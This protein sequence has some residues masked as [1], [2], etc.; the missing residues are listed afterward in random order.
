MVEYAGLNRRH[1]IGVFAYHLG[2]L[3]LAYLR[4]LSCQFKHSNNHTST[5]GP[6]RGEGKG[7]VSPGPQHLG[8]PPSDNCAAH[9]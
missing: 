4:Q 7:E 8:A 5:A 2:V 1:V 3:E 9:R 6:S